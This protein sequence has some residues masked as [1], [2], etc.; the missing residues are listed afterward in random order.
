M[1]GRKKKE[2]EYRKIEPPQELP[3][4]PQP[5]QKDVDH[6]EE[7]KERIKLLE[8]ELGQPEE[9]A[10]EPKPKEKYVEVPVYL[11]DE[12]AK[13]LVYENNRILKEI[14]RLVRE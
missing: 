7:L 1:L 14:H 13:M 6:I 2:P 8:S 9:P 12:N 5:T 10:T 3:P 11:T 4:L